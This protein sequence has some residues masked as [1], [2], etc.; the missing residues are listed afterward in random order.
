MP[1]LNK[2]MLMGNLTRDPELRYTPNGTA[3]ADL[4]LAINRKRKGKDGDWVEETTFV[5]VT[6]WG[7]QAEIVNEYFSKGRPIYIEGRLQLDEWT[8]PEGQKRSK[9]KV[10]LESFEFLSSRGDSGGGGGGGGG[11]QQQRPRQQQQQQQQRQQQQPPRQ[12][13]PVYDNGPSDEP[14]DDVPF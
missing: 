10:V 13:E 6:A 2:V 8:S 9:L 12:S 7:R 1:N 5:T 3:V 4:G 14:F 11:G